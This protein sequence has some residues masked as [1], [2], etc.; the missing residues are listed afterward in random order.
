MT[1]L[2]C[3]LMQSGGDTFELS[4]GDTFELFVLMQSGGDTFELF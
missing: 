3:V 2:N 1:L 4:G